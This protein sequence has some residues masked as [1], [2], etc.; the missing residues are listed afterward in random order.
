MAEINVLH[1]FREG[2]GRTQRE[3]IRTLAIRNGF[4]LDWSRENKDEVLHASIR[5]KDD[6]TDLAKVIE[7]SITNTEPNIAIK[8]S[9]TRMN[10]KSFDR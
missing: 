1:P 9:F 7:H 5:S 6:Y 4:E 10:E 8:K 3:F 2:N